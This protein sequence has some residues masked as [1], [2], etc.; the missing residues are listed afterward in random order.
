MGQSPVL[1]FFLGLGSTTACMGLNITRA[2]HAAKVQ[3]SWIPFHC[4]I[5]GA[6][7]DLSFSSLA[8][9]GSISPPFHYVAGCVQVRFAGV[10]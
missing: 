9:F 10:Q 2:V 6:A 8:L 1:G 5:L 4:F 3:S 7:S